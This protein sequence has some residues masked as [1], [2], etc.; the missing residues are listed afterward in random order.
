[1]PS[2]VISFRFGDAEIHALHRQAQP[3][4]SFNQ[5]AQRLL[6]EVLEVREPSLVNKVSTMLST[7]EFVRH[8]DL[9]NI[10]TRNEFHDLKELINGYKLS[11]MRE[12]QN[13]DKGISLLAEQ[14]AEL[15]ARLDTMPTSGITKQEL[16]SVR[17]KVL[18][19]WKLA[20]APEKK[21]RIKQGIDKVIDLVSS[22]DQSSDSKLE[23][24]PNFDAGEENKE[25]QFKR[26]NS[27]SRLK[28]K[29]DSVVGEENE[30]FQFKR[31]KPDSK[32][33]ININPT[34]LPDKRKPLTALEEWE[35][36]CTDN[37]D[38]IAE[39]WYEK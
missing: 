4:E 13:R 17:D 38:E 8:Q 32:P 10:P 26:R 24:K 3:G 22:T 1:M 31:K 19:S 29:S 21:E 14:V 37:I 27:K 36:I 35:E 15:T 18:Q 20:K 7:D 9:I 12:I 16:E 25:F 34:P 11:L 6:R 5:T 23:I 33:K 2:Q 39:D 30:E 28:I